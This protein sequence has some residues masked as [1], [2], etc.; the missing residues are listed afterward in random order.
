MEA[1]VTKWCHNNN[2]ALNVNKK[3]SFSTPVHPD[4]FSTLI[5]ANGATA[6]TVN[7]LGLLGLHI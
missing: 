5:I 4:R 1:D 2:L 7:C 3:N 6:E